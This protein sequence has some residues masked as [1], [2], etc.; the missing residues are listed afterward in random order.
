M[1]LA[2][3]LAS[4][5]R[6]A[7]IY[8]AT[9]G[10]PLI[11]KFTDSGMDKGPIETVL[12]SGEIMKGEFSTVDTSAAAGLIMPGSY[13]GVVTMAGDRGTVMKCDYS[14]NALTGSGTGNCQTNNGASYTL[15]F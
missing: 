8:A 6:E 11:A 15:H 5:S 12:P 13:P 7:R 10:A 1:A 9:G 14:V 2:L 4:C 3:V